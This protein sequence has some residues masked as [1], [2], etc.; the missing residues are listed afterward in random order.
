MR[1]NVLWEAAK[2]I[3]AIKLPHPTRVGIDGLSASGKTVFAD[4]LVQPLE[5]L[6]RHVIRASIDGFH[7]PSDIRYRRGEHSI[8]G[9][10]DDSF[11][12]QA[13]VNNVLAPLGP[14]GDF[15]YK[16]SAFDFI[17]NQSMS[18]IVEKAQSDSIL[19]FEGVMLF[20]TD[21][22]PHWDYRIFIDASL[23]V[24]FKRAVIRDSERLGGSDKLAKKYQNRYLPGQR[25]YISRYKPHETAHLMIN[26]NNY[27]EPYI[28]RKIPPH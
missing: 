20:C 5:Q 19:L 24:I 22:A 14:G 16:G 8:D 1:D 13:V 27:H 9:Y 25:Q 12:Y 6:G 11:N 7:N 3:H 28:V 26:N 21:L 18:A 15:R 2:A 17:T 10:I 23:D 4:D